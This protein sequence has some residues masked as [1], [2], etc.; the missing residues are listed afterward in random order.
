MRRS[1]AKPVATS[2]RK[3][4]DRMACTGC[5][6][7]HRRTAGPGSFRLGGMALR[8][9]TPGAPTTA[10]IT[11]FEMTVPPGGFHPEAHS[12]VE[13][14]ELVLGIAG[15]LTYSID[16]VERVL[17]AGE[18][19]FCPHGSVHQFRNDGHAPAQVLM[20]LAPG[21]IGIDFFREAADLVK[22]GSPDQA[23]MQALTRRYGLVPA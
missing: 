16:G 10:S 20:V 13:A 14:D 15:A 1:D 2:S 17:H 8:F 5:G 11:S 7:A 9:L 4:R 21:T 6:A 19:A 23:K 18:S 3:M 22:A 12:H